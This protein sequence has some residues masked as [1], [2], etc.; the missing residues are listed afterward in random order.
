MQKIC[1]F[2]GTTEGRDLVKY[3]SATQCRVTACVATEY[4]EV[5][6]ENTTADIKVGRLQQ[7]DMLTMFLKEKFDLVVDT[8]H[9]FATVVSENVYMACEQAD[10]EYMRINRQGTLQKGFASIKA[11]SEYLKST[12]GNILLTTGSKEI[13]QFNSL[14]DFAKRVY[15]RVLPMESSI[16]ECKNAGLEGSHIIAMQGPFTEEMNIAMIDYLN[17]KILVTKNSGDN[18]GFFE[19]L[20]AAGKT[21][22]ECVIVNPPLQKDGLSY[23]QGIVAIN[24]RLGV[25]IRPKISIIGIG[26]GSEKHMTIEAVESIK[27][28]DAIIGAKRVIDGCKSYGKPCYSGFTA[29]D[30]IEVLQKNPEYQR[31]AVVMSGD[32]GFYSGAKKLYE[33]LVNFDITLVCGISTPV[34]FSSRLKMSWEDIKL[35][36]LHGKESNV[37]HAV[38][39]NKKVFVLVG[40]DDGVQ[41]LCKTLCQYG[42]CE[43]TVHVGENLSYKNEKITTDTAK[44]MSEQSFDTL[45]AVIIENPNFSTFQNIGIADEDFER[46]KSVPMTKQEIR[47]V[48][49]SKLRLSA[50]SIVYDIGAGTGAVSVECACC[51]F[52]G[53]VY[54]VEKNEQALQAITKNK[55]KFKL[56]NLQ[57]ING[58]APQALTALEKP[59][60]A[61]IGGSSGN[62]EE[63]LKV[64]L[65]KNPKIR[66]VVNVIALETL[67]QT[68]AVIDK[69]Q[70]QEVDI[71]QLNV[72]KSKRVG[73][74]NMMMGQNPIYIISCQGR[75]I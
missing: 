65:D 41:N 21:N 24:K 10:I 25:A 63:I 50:N 44:K 13:Q 9:P 29:S 23:A 17:I 19:K 54:A 58:F 14:Q 48:S 28:S 64:L 3:L 39:T 68:L 72:S 51:A 4:G 11:A 70:L 1:V 52:D 22:I 30:I 6:L 16:V 12:T 35:T 8:T 71:V 36:S 75:G 57:E 46:I 15:A 47:A 38:K 61:F 45:S 66:I 60:H 34:Y 2:A 33:Q 49:L 43:L 5:S 74:Y 27:A 18:G 31:I 69:F 62:M 73:S 56:Q 53:R 7:S 67:S 55:F 32:I 20:S 37:I 26:T 59:T 42:F 40:G